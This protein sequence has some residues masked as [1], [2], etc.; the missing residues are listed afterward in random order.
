[1]QKLTEEIILQYC[2]D[3]SRKDFT[4]QFEILLLLKQWKHPRDS[5]PLMF[6]CTIERTVDDKTKPTCTF[7]KIINVFMLHCT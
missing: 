4:K 2:K 5:E 7:L 1:M 3:S 6:I